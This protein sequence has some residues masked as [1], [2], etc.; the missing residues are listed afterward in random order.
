[1]V[2]SDRYFLSSVYK[3]FLIFLFFCEFS[4]LI[5]WFGCYSCV[6]SFYYVCVFCSTQ[7]SLLRLDLFIAAY[8]RKKQSL[9]LCLKCI[10]NI[11]FI[12]NSHFHIYICMRHPKFCV[13]TTIYLC[14]VLSCLNVLC[15]KR[16]ALIIIICLIFKF[17]HIIS[18]EVVC[19][20]EVRLRSL[21]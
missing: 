9:F 13:S 17:Y 4:S 5:D 1:M 10:S 3:M 21:N 11:Q 12:P 6:L 18:G 15:A 7:S 20:V 8:S 2:V 16:W 14:S 19:A